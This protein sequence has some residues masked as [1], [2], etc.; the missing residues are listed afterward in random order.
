M[1]LGPVGIPAAEPAWANKRVQIKAAGQVLLELKT[2]WRAGTTRLVML[3]REFMQRL[4][5]PVPRS[6]LHR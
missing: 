1:H 4:A 3:P 2:A 6:R 5:A